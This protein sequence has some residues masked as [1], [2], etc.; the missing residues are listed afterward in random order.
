M[1]FRMIVIATALCITPVALQAQSTTP[2][3][4]QR[5]EQS[6]VTEPKAASLRD[7]LMPANA[8]LRVTAP[9]VTETALESNPTITRT[10]V[11]RSS[12]TALMIVG[13]ALFVAGLLADG[14]AGTLL[15]VA[16]AG[17]G[18]YGLYLHFR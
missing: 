1:T 12:G 3:Q 4:P 7:K 15:V 8:G 10:A 13:G 14:D 18:A 9:S 16:G 5:V 17:I 2:E 6:Q 11:A